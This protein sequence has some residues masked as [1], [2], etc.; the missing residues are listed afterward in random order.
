ML[1]ASIFIVVGI[2]AVVVGFTAFFGAP[3]LP[4]RRRDIAVLF[5]E[6]FPISEKDLVVDMGSGDGVVLREASRRGARAFGIEMHPLFYWISKWLSKSDAK[7]QVKLGDAW[8]TPL[9]SETSLVYIF[10]VKRDMK[11]VEK[12]LQ[13]EANRIG[14]ALVLASYGNTIVGR[15]ARRSLGAFHLYEFTPLQ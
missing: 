4:S 9:P 2:I 12:H 5:D 11:R 13:A 14:K 15:T 3:Y 1:I 7:V 6:V 8:T 10:S